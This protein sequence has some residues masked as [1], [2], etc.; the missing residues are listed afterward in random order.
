MSWTYDFTRRARDELA[1][2]DKVVRERIKKYL[3]WLIELPN[4]KLRGKQLKGDLSEFWRYTVGDYR[5][6]CSIEEDKLLVLVVKIGH[7]KEVYKWR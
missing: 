4:P 2:L 3:K 1:E 7:R 5:I 6:V